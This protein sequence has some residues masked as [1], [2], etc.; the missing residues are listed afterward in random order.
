[1]R[2][3]VLQNQK[4]QGEHLQLQF[5]CGILPGKRA[6]ELHCLK[7]QEEHLER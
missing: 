6:P 2:A 1:M 5:E 4:A 3:L 7:D